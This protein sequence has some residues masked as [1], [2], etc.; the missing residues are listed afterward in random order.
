M[1]I[2]LDIIGI[3]ILSIP[4]LW[5]INNDKN[6]DAHIS[7]GFLS[8]TSK[9]VDVLARLAL[10]FAGGAINTILNDINIYKSVFIS[11]AIHFFFFDY[12]IAYILIKKGIIIGHWFS[13]TGSKGMDNTKL[14]KDLSPTRKF[15]LKLIILII[16]IIVYFN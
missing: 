1:R 10:A 6:G 15:I 16:A 14:W 3:F 7:R 5:E 8:W 4:L 12:I 9:K 11:G 2:F 13:Y